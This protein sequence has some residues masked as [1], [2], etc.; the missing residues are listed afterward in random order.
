MHNDK[1]KI[2]LPTQ[3]IYAVHLISMTIKFKV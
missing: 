2:F 1:V 3:C